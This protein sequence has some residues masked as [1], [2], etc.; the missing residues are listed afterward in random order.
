MAN[1]SDIGLANPSVA[2]MCA[3]HSRTMPHIIPDGQE[4]REATTKPDASGCKRR[5]NKSCE[6]IGR[7]ALVPSKPLS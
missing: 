1:Q 2:P 3:T 4:R 5:N 7:R 6:R